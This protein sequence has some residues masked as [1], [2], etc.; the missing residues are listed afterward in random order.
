[1]EIEFSG[2]EEEHKKL[3]NDCIKQLKKF[4][5][6]ESKKE[7]MNKIKQYESK[8]L[9]EESIKLAQETYRTTKGYKTTIVFRK[10]VI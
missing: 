10:E 8:G 6:E 2:N 4:K 3:I 9:L 7:I 5:L 1:M